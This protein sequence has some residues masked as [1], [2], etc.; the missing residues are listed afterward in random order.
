MRSEVAIRAYA[1]EACVLGAEIMTGTRI[2]GWERSP[3]GVRVDTEER[4]YEARKLVVTAGP[5][6]GQLLPGLRPL[7]RPERQVMLWT[8]PLN[9][10]AF[11]PGRFPVFN[12]ERRPGATT[13]FPTT[14]ARASRL[15]ST[16]TCGSR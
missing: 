9:A 16:T 12:M 1:A 15:A 8:R 6:V 14:A 4:A 5:W 3:A 13:V 2:R 10:A 11:D 7:C